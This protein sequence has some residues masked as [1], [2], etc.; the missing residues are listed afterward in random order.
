MAARCL[1]GKTDKRLVAARRDVTASPERRD[2]YLLKGRWSRAERVR[3]GKKTAR[4]WVMD[5]FH[6]LPGGPWWMWIGLMSLYKWI[7]FMGTYFIHISGAFDDSFVTIQSP[8]WCGCVSFKRGS[9]KNKYCMENT[10]EFIEF[11]HLRFELQ[12][13]GCTLSIQPGS[14]ELLQD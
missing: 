7:R 1:L 9:R 6:C 10:F 8:P 2:N 14:S 3:W 12:C 5:S 4:L 11:S 13:Q